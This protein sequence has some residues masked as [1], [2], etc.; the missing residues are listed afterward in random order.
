MNFIL[1]YSLKRFW[2]K[3]AQILTTA[4]FLCLGFWGWLLSESTQTSIKNRLE[5]NARNILAADLTIDVRREF[6]KQELSDFRKEIE[7]KGKI[8]QSYEFFAMLTTDQESRL[9]QV[10]VIDDFYPFY[11]IVKLENR[12]TIT[13]LKQPQIWAYAEL[14]N[15]MDL[16]LNESIQLG[17]AKFKV[18]DFISEDQTQT[19]RLA[20]L[21]PT[22][23]IHLTNLKAT[24]LIQFG[25]TFSSI[26]LVKL[27]PAIDVVELSKKLKSVLKDPGIDVTTYK[28]LPDDL[29]GPTQR[30]SDFLGLTSLVSLLFCSLS[31]FYLLQIWSSEQQKEKA[32]LAVFGLSASHIQLI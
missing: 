5:N 12:S 3:R 22:I 9:V 6:T 21:A 27:N 2:R 25:S 29:S 10:R 4:F 31:L 23:F 15:L 8:S 16:K 11:G 14:K 24:K 30:L 17:E 32:A 20:S 18:G 7:G 26:E 19:F 28:S 1:A 13:Q